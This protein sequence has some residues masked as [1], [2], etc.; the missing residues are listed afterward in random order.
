[1]YRYLLSYAYTRVVF[2][3][4]WRQSLN[5]LFSIRFNFPEVLLY[6][7]DHGNSAMY[8]AC[9]HLCSV[10]CEFQIII[11]DFCV[12]LFLT[13]DEQPSLNVQLYIP[14]MKHF[15]LILIT[16]TLFDQKLYKI[17][18]LKLM[19]QIVGYFSR[20][21]GV[22]LKFESPLQ[23]NVVDF[24]MHLQQLASSWCILATLVAVLPRESSQGKLSVS[25]N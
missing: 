23:V 18:E 1:M 17:I 4:N 12:K 24:S 9:N 25:S 15:Q 10:T 16:I 2:I 13:K 14:K 21:E 20:K 3:Y 8:S 7:L 5:F 19:H 6:H 11:N 22:F